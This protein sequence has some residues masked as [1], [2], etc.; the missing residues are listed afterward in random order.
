M[1]EKH[2]ITINVDWHD[3]YIDRNK[4]ID[5]FL[6]FDKVPGFVITSDYFK[7]QFGNDN[8]P[9]ITDA[10]QEIA[11]TIEKQFEIRQEEADDAFRGKLMDECQS[12][13]DWPS[14]GEY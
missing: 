5:S 13:I 1:N 3:I 14:I 11:L 8:Y 10:M 4:D 2:L 7:D 9:T 12:Q 6:D